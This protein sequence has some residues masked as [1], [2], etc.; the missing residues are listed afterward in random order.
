PRAIS[1]DKPRYGRRSLRTTARCFRATAAGECCVDPARRTTPG[2]FFK[3][4]AARKQQLV[5]DSLSGLLYAQS[6][7]GDVDAR[8]V[9]RGG[10]ILLDPGIVPSFADHPGYRSVC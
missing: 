5:D 2:D 6:G 4:S 1:T 3:R 8:L 7:R 9:R 10:K